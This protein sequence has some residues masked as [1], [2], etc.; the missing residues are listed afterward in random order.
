MADQLEGTRTLPVKFQ[1]QGD[2]SVAEIV[3]LPEGIVVS[4]VTDVATLS[5]ASTPATA[6]VTS[7]SAEA[8]A[9]NASREALSIVNIGTADVYLGLGAAALDNKGIVLLANGGSW[10]GLI[11]GKLWTGQVRAKTASGTSTLAVQEA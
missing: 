5:T 11:S 7:T 2:G 3:A 10:D 6:A 1:D 4:V 9:A 8:V